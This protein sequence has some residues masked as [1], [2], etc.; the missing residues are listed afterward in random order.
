M[1]RKVFV[2]LLFVEALGAIALAGTRPVSLQIYVYNEAGV[3]QKFLLPAEQRTGRI[4]RVAGIESLWLDCRAGTSAQGCAGLLPPDTLIIR[5]IHDSRN[6]NG[7]VFGAAFL[8]L[9][10]SGVYAN[11]FYDRLRRFER[12]RQIS[13]V[14]LLGHVMAHEIGHLLGLSSHSNLGI[15]QAAW[16]EDQLR[17]AERGELLFSAEESRAIHRK[18]AAVR[19][20]GFA[21]ASLH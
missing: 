21:M 6:L 3:P 11:V 7:D 19:Q 12:D 1:S 18:L 10:G 17:R 5:I 20:A 9:D 13:P 16:D 2:V 14:A 4:L 15:M 8:G